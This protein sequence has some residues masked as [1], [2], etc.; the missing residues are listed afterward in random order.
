MGN[1]EIH[2]QWGYDNKK[3]NRIKLRREYELEEFNYGIDFS[4]LKT[5]S[6]Q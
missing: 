2:E 6:D 4:Q 1:R 5:S 3:Y